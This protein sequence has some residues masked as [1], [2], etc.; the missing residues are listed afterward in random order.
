MTYICVCVCVRVCVCLCVCVCVLRYHIL[1]CIVFMFLSLTYIAPIMGIFYIN[2]GKSI[3]MQV[4][5]Y[6]NMLIAAFLTSV[7]TAIANAKFFGKER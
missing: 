2:K 6:G 5:T 7:L 4:Y 3:C 1:S